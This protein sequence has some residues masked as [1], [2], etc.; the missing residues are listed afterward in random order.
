MNASSY[1][2]LGFIV[3]IIS[4]LLFYGLKEEHRAWRKGRTARKHKRSATK[5]PP[6][7]PPKSEEPPSSSNAVDAAGPHEDQVIE[8]RIQSGEGDPERSSE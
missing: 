8:E 2:S 1:R 3:A 7:T 5:V 4:L 6:V